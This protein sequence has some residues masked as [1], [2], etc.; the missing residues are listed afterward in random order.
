MAKELAAAPED[1][2]IILASRDLKKVDS[3]LNDITKTGQ[4]KNTLSTLQLDVTD[5]ASIDKAAATVREKHGHLDVLVNNAGIAPTGPNLTEMFENTFATNVYGPVHVSAAFRPL[6]L[7]SKEGSYSIY[8]SSEVGAL[9]GMT[10]PSNRLYNTHSGSV[11]YRAS[12]SALNM[13]AMHERLETEGTGLKVRVMCP[14]FVIS[15]LRGTDEESRTAGGQ[16]GDPT[17][18]ANL[19]LSILRGGREDESH[20]LISAEGPIPW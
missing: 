17:V 1:F 19:L 7:A 20:K 18:S 16:A 13:I 12:K 5:Q 14:G 2:H 4:P 6:L 3:A 9:T 15:N 11:A 8:V 10:D